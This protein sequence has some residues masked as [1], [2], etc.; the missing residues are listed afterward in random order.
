M[1]DRRIRPD[2]HASTLTRASAPGRGLTYCLFIL[3]CWSATHRY[4]GLGYDAQLYA[5]Q[6]LARIHPALNLDLF[7]VNSSQDRFSVFSPFYA[8]AIRLL[9]LEQAALVLMLLFS[10]AFLIGAWFLMR[11]LTDA[12]RAWLAIVL[13]V[14]IPGDFGA[15]NVIRYAEPFLTARTAAEA[16]VVI[17]LALCL[18]SRPLTAAAV[19]AVAL[20]FHP[21]MALPGLLMLVCLRLPMRLCTATAGLGVIGALALAA[22]AVANPR[23]AQWVPLLD[24]DWLYMV[25]ERS[26]Y[27]LLDLWTATDWKV[28][29]KPFVALLLTVLAVPDERIRR[30]SLAAMLVGVTG[31][32]VAAIGC[33]VGPVA[34]LVQ[35]QP[36]RFVW[37]TLLMAVLLLP[38]TAMT[39][40]REPRV[41][42]P[43]AALA[44]LV[45]AFPSAAP[46][47][48]GTLA[49]VMWTV[50]DLV[51]ERMARALRWLAAVAIAIA[52]AWLIV[53]AGTA[54]RA[55]LE[56]GHDSPA[57]EMTRRL[58]TQQGLVLML[59]CVGWWWI[60][61]R[62]HAGL[63]ATAAA[64]VIALVLLLPST[65]RQITSLSDVYR[66]GEF[67]DWQRL[68]PENKSVVIANQ[69]AASL[70]IWFVL[71]RISYLTEAQSSGVVFARA[72]ALE[73][74]RRSEVLAPLL[75]PN[76]KIF[77]A[78]SAY[79][80][81]RSSYHPPGAHPLTAAILMNICADPLLGF[82]IA[83]QNV[84]F[85]AHRHV[86]RGIW[87]NW[88]LYDCDVV[89]AA[90]G[91]TPGG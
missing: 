39:L 1:T 68:I 18:R 32:A 5:F 62:G 63:M 3:V 48:L 20:F 75:D 70:F 67:A 56:T 80:K 42:P 7:L 29:A 82:L 2:T 49:A 26:Q 47:E 57:I 50:R 41:G 64:L 74:R 52:V 85:N 78:L 21:I 87:S 14:I 53:K 81:D 60:A 31:L 90:R 66:P 24:P 79:A 16:L 89:R 10:T 77:S 23:I 35:S 12:S 17:A 86:G 88:N 13:L 84:G 4:Q 33:V 36:W 22:A 15:F 40:W 25:R 83:P 54:S 37:V 38:A 11:R 73:V 45:W 6:A 51:T 44:A 46:L 58:L 65:F 34:I 76:W 8:Q 71:Q 55:P 91:S 28:N 61:G 9:D 19:I 72:T 59:A 69:N 43:C 30:L 27:L